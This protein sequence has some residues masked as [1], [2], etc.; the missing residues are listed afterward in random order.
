[1]PKTNFLAKLKKKCGVHSET[2]N[3]QRTQNTIGQIHILSKAVNYHASQDGTLAEWTTEVNTKLFEL[4]NKLAN[5][6]VSAGPILSELEKL[7]NKLKDE[8]KRKRKRQKLEI[9]NSESDTELE[10]DP[11]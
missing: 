1:M 3:R 6:T 4:Q 2:V 5:P 8:L 7:Q 11:P 9:Q 10:N